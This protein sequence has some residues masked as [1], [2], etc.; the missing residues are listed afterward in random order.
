MPVLDLKVHMDN[1]GYVIHEYYEKPT[2]NPNVILPRSAL[3]W[4]VKRTVFTQEALRRIRNTSQRLGPHAANE[5]LSNFMLKFKMAGYNHQFR[6]EIIK[7][8]KHAFNLQL[9]SAADGEKPL[10]RDKNRILEDQKCCIIC[11]HTIFSKRRAA[12]GNKA[13]GLYCFGSSLLI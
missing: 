9:K 5:V 3:S 13:T 12:A 10:Y 7:S 6:A 11:S 2:K 4:N 1:E 8:A